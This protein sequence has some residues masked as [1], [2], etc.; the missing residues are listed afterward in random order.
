MPVIVLVLLIIGAQSMFGTFLLQDNII[1]ASGM[2][3]FAVFGLIYVVY[4]QATYYLF[5]RNVCM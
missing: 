3:T 5:K 1:P 4:Y 2:I